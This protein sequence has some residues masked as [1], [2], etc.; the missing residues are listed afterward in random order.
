MLLESC[1]PV[2][3]AVGESGE[4]LPGQLDK[5]II[6]CRADDVS[7]IASLGRTLA[8]W[9]EE[10]LNHHRTGASNGPTE[11]MKFWAKQVKRAGRGL[12]TFENYAGLRVLLYAGGV[13]W[14]VTVQARRLSRTRPH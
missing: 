10:I 13:T 7:E 3:P 6:A 4:E 2:V 5:A 12:S 11:G 1:E 9:R 8:R 14:P